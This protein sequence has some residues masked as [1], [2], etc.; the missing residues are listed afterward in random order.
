M[1]IELKKPPIALKG[2]MPN[3]LAKTVLTMFPEM[4]KALQTICTPNTKRK[5]F[6]CG[7]SSGGS[8]AMLFAHL[9]ALFIKY[10]IA[11]V[12]TFGALPAGNDEWK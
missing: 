3:Y 2:V 9:L 10:D 6:I 7:H 11:A 5:F 1:K 8:V 12:Y 4:E